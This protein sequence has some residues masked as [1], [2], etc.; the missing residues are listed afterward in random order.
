MSQDALTLDLAELYEILSTSFVRYLV[1]VSDPPCY[2]EKDRELRDFLAALAKENETSI[3]TLA[4][5]LVARDHLPTRGSFPL[6]FTNYNFLRPRYLLRPLSEE[7]AKEVDRVVSSVALVRGVTDD[8]AVIG[9]LERIFASEKMILDRVEA[10]AEEVG[11]E[12][13][14]EPQGPKGTSASRW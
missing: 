9:A 5:L 11:P 1:D 6:V 2:D 8:P 14:R 3:E 4:E 7:L 10:M 13:H 12:R